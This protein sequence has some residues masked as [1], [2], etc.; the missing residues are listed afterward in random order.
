MSLPI[1]MWTMLSLTMAAVA[2]PFHVGDMRTAQQRRPTGSVTFPDGTRVQVEIAAD[3]ATRQRG[4]MFRESMA[5][6]EGMVFVFDRPGIYPFWMKNTL[7]S[8]DMLWL[9]QSGRIVH[10]AHSVPPC[11]ADPCP[12]YPP[13]AEAVYV[14]EVVAGFART[15]KLKVGD[16]LKLTGVPAPG[17]S[18]MP[19][20]AAKRAVQPPKYFRLH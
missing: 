20:P 2:S 18:T 19:K 11:K 13:D 9:D 3:E 8:L 12:S 10:I 6:N 16:Q 1:S 5:P 4:L 17:G 15:H 7:I 14:V